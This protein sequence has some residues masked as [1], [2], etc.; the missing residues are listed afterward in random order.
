[1]TNEPLARRRVLRVA[2]VAGIVAVAGCAGGDTDDGDESDD[3]G[4]DANGPD[5][6]TDD[7][8]DA[9]DAE[10][11]DDDDAD[12]EDEGEGDARFGETVRM[13]DAYAY[14]AE[15][16]VEG[17][18]VEWIGRVHGEDSY[19][20]L[21]GDEGTRESYVIGDETYWVEGDECF[22]MGPGEAIQEDP[23]AEDLEDP[24]FEDETT[25]HAE[26]EP[27]GTDEIDGEQVYVFEL[28]AAEDGAV[29]EDTTYYVS[30]DTGYIH[31]IEFEEGT[32]DFHSWGAVDP[33]EPPEM[34]CMEIGGM[35]D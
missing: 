16:E 18:R 21:E 4:D 24:D 23:E 1:M 19:M 34:E 27:A 14:E 5:D 35:S 29:D 11:E 22:L 9:D 20:R 6:A 31:R 28:L 17:E 26:L 33:I 7:E 32:M 8:D 12:D 25:E 2:G 13:A 30:V 10:A 3:T 15:M